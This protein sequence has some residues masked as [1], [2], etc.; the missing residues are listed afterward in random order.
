MFILIIIIDK[1]IMLLLGTLFN[2]QNPIYIGAPI[3]V[4]V[5]WQVT[6]AS[7]IANFYIDQDLD[8]NDIKFKI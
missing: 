8:C 2:S 7:S 6:S 1:I 3:Y 5:G 4:S